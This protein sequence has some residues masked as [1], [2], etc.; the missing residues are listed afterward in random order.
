MHT[1]VIMAKPTMM[2]CGQSAAVLFN[3]VK[4]AAVTTAKPMAVPIR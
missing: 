2:E 4:T 1:A 3:V